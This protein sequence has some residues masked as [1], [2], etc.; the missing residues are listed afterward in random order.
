M[1]ITYEQHS[2]RY[3][4]TYEMY[5]TKFELFSFYKCKTFRCKIVFR[6]RE[7]KM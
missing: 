6:F 3:R 4:P 1:Y 5:L 7:K 2:A